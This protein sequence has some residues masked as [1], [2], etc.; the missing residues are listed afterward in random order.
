MSKALSMSLL[1]AKVVNG[2]SNG[3][4]G[5]GVVDGIVEGNFN[6]NAMTMAMQ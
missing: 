6:G 1:N 4:N 3:I 5:S 2:N